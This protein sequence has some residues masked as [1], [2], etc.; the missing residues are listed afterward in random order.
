MK[1]KDDCF[2]VEQKLVIK[3]SLTD[4]VN[5][6]TDRQQRPCPGCRFAVG[7]NRSRVSTTYCS[8]NCSAAPREMSSDPERYPIEVGIVPLVYAFYTMRL[9]MPCW[10][11][12]GHADANG[13]TQKTPKLWFYTTSDFYPKLVAQYVSALKGSHQIENHWAVRLL[14]FS[15]SMFTITYCLEPQESATQLGQLNSLQNDIKVI[16]RNFRQELHKLARHY[17]DRAEKNG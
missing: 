5:Q 12:E 11:C 2:K 1:I 4:L 16:A 13:V 17:I 14:P 9:M 7:H 8:A 15:Q 10:S 3:T 6:P